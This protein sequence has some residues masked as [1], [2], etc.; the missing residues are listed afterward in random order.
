MPS[1]ASSPS[2]DPTKKHFTKTKLSLGPVSDNPHHSFAMKHALAV[3]DSRSVYTYIPKNACTTMRY[4][5]ARNN[6]FIDAATDVA[7]HH[8]NNLTFCASQE[9]AAT[10]DYAFVVLRCPFRRIASGYLDKVVTLNKVVRSLYPTKLSKVQLRIMERS[11][12]HRLSFRDFVERIAK[13]DRLE[14]NQHWRPQ[15][16]FMLYEA[17]DDYFS[18]ED[19]DRAKAELSRKIDFPIY[20]TRDAVGHDT[21]KFAKISGAY[22]DTPAGVLFKMRESG[23]LPSYESLYDPSLIAR[24]TDIYADDIA[25]YKETCGI[26]GLLFFDTAAPQSGA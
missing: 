2:V 13:I 18:V 22:A 23:Q 11:M 21:K 8:S 6:R 24:V 17:Y 4:S 5:I 12:Y 15:A 20:D 26:A 9:F 10:A 3:Y 14:L 19:F 25:L 1:T 16:D 7:W